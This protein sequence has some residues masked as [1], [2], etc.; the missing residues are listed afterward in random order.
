MYIDK[1]ITIIQKYINEYDAK[2]YELEY[3]AVDFKK[4]DGFLKTNRISRELN[5]YRQ[6]YCGCKFSI[7]TDT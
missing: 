7:R 5:L 3:L 2:K 4:K 1:I 6:N